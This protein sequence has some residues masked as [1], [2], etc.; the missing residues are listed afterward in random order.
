M[1]FNEGMEET[2]PLYT[3]NRYFSY[4]ITF[5]SNFFFSKEGKGKNHKVKSKKEQIKM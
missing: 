1:L 5:P 2:L 3:E 4:T